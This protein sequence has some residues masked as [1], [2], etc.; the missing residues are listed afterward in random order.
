MTGR[1]AILVDGSP[2][3]LVVPAVLID[4]LSTAE[5]Y[6]LNNQYSNFLRII[7]AISLFFALFLPGLYVAI[8]N[9]HQELLPSELLFA[10]SGA[11]ESIPFPIIFEIIIMEISF[12]LIREAQLRVPSPFGQTIGIIGALILGEA[13]V[14][15]S[16]VSPILIIVIAFTGICSFAIPDFSFAFSIRIFRFF[17]IIG[18]FLAGFLGIGFVFFI[19]FILLCRLNS[20][21]VSYLSPYLPFNE[22]KNFPFYYVNPIWKKE[23]RNDF[24]KTKRPFEEDLISMNWRKNGKK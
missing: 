19:Q 23:R 17:Y 6:N 18:G 5:D 22:K 14:N 16:I 9:F 7:R 1:I 4:F 12:E 2:F 10:I 20:F 13:S 21:G 3:A 24:L 8:T 11:R 15:A